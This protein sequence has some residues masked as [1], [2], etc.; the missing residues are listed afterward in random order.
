[1]GKPTVSAHKNQQA[2]PMPSIAKL[3]IRRGTVSPGMEWASINRRQIDAMIAIAP[4]QRHTRPANSLADPIP[5][6]SDCGGPEWIVLTL[7][8]PAMT[9]TVSEPGKIGDFVKP[10][11]ES[12]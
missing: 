3:L 2:S 4:S 5:E 10:Y 6:E 12:L 9:I 8:S 1:V 11:C 7:L